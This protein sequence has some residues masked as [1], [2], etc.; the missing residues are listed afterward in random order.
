MRE[1]EPGRIRSRDP[2]EIDAR[3]DAALR[4][5]A[6]PTEIPEM[7]FVLAR[8]ME[9]ARAEALRQPSWWLWGAV[10]AGLATMLAVGVV[11]M[12]RAPRRPEIAWTPKAPAV[13]RAEAP[14]RGATAKP[15]EVALPKSK[16]LKGRGR[17]HEVRNA[18]TNQ[19]PKLDVFPTPRPLTAQEE[20]LV[21]FV[22]Q[23]PPAV[24][25]AV[26]DDQQHWDDP[27]H[28]ADLQKPLGNS[29]STQDQ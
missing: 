14:S 27:I 25:K 10:A 5:Y 13:A 21:A 28:V 15:Q 18:A 16:E 19:P 6:A 20:A 29:G 12:M 7:R 24:K 26:L 2:G 4:S 3:I 17:I 11:W 1:D 23:A 8:V 22:K 9:R